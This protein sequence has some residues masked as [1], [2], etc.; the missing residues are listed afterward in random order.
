MKPFVNTT[1]YKEFA[2]RMYK[3]NC[4]ER[5]AYGMEVHPTFQ[6]YEESNR[7]FLKEKYRNSQ[8]IQP[9]VEPSATRGPKER[10]RIPKNRCKISVDVLNETLSLYL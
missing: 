7:N 5:R 10:I 4:T 2:L 3:K 9:P 1:E 8:L 6:A